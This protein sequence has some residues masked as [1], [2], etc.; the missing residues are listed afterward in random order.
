MSAPG[1]LRMSL[2]SFERLAT[3]GD[4]VPVWCDLAGDTETPVSAF[5]KL[6]D[7][8]HAFLLESVQGGER[9]GRFSFLGDSP[10]ALVRQSGSLVTV[11]EGGRTTSTEERH[12]LE[13]LR[14]L[15]GRTRFVRPEGAPPFVG[16]LVGYLGSGAVRWFEPRVPQQHGP[17][18]LFPDGEWMLSQRVAVFDNLA[19]RLRVWASVRVPA[20]GSVE[21]AYRA[22]VQET[23]VLA[24][25][26]Q[27]PLPPQAS[28][29]PLGKLEDGWER[30]GFEASVARAREYIAAGDCMQVVLSRRLTASYSGPPF[31][32]YRALRTVS[33][34]PY[35]FYLRFGE[36]ALAG[37]SPELLVRLQGRTVTVRP[38][39]GTRPR[40]VTA[41]ADA[42]LEAEL[43][44]DPKERAEHVMLVDL[45][46]NDVGR[47]SRT[48]TVRVEEREVVERY[49]HVMHLVSQVSGQLLEKQDAFDVLAAC[50]PAGTVSGAPKVRALQIVDELEP[51]SRGPYA[52]AAGYVGF[53]GDMDLAIAIRSVAL[54][55]STLRLQAGAGIVYDSQ[56]TAEYQET[57]Y[58]LRA[59]LVALAAD[60]GEG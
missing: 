29:A 25:A 45:G 40:G 6:P 13:P 33:P 5:L 43:R 1:D 38:I 21:A 56:P 8:R 34:T 23:E 51:C 32:L 42:Q 48:G 37:A 28:F 50:F 17:D 19:H 46:R 7:P 57:A 39:A 36:R 22:A 11:E 55:G 14:R 18:P 30:S 12:P 27:R 10:V 41:E 47:V 2:A 4:L 20:Y 31:H 54:S 44:A 49:S 59:A 3:L 35:L 60:G 9:W 24:E 15:L 26:L 58:K 53:D 16:G 52:G